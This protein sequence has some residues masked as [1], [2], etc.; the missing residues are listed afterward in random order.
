MM[1]QKDN[2]LYCKP[3]RIS[4][5]CFLVVA[6]MF[7]TR[8]G[9]GKGSYNRGGS[10]KAMERE[11]KFLN[12]ETLVAHKDENT[13]EL[14]YKINTKGFLYKKSSDALNFTARLQIKCKLYLDDKSAKLIDTASAYIQDVDESQREKMMLGK[15]N[16]NTRQI[17]SYEL[18]VQILDINSNNSKTWKLYFDRKAKNDV[19]YFYLISAKDSIP[20]FNQALKPNANYY[21]I[22][23]SPNQEP[24]KV[25]HYTNSRKL[26]PP[27]F[28][29]DTDDE[30]A[31]ILDSSFLIQTKANTS[32]RF[33]KEGIYKFYLGD[34]ISAI[35][36]R[37][38]LFHQHFPQIG[39]YD[40]M[41]A[42][43]RFILNKDEF[44]TLTTATD[45]QA[46]VEKQW[47][48]FAGNKERAEKVI[49]SYYS[50][51]ETANKSYTS[52]L[53]GWKTDRGLVR[54]IFGAP[55]RINTLY[56]KEIWVYYIGGNFNQV[57][58]EFYKEEKSG[59]MIL[60]RNAVYKDL[61][62]YAVDA[63]RQGRP[64]LRD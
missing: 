5:W 3:Y 30:G 38:V 8:C 33:D 20:I 22:N 4:Y 41:I 12:S 47:L 51:V 19:N 59:E 54:I 28:S 40:N 36:K 31:L 52:T 50:R 26:P 11:L 44:K 2:I 34:S 9:S 7:L 37:S 56:N 58:F 15:I 24:V 25:A 27:I 55:D 57:G 60:F 14:I 63:W 16:L 42:G 18:E 1:K 43:M 13:S 45:K 29:E 17:G 61:W 6:L 21:L 62:Y 35:Y 23:R 49:K 53:E 46:A 10:G 39:T 64:F 48:T 32:L